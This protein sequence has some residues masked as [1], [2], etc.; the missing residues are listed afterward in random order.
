MPGSSSKTRPVFIRLPVEAYAIVERRI[1]KQAKL[2][3]VAL[4]GS[5]L[6]SLVNK[7]IKA[8]IIFF[9]RRKHVKTRLDKEAT[10]IK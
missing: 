8:T 7:Y 10:I 2:R 5:D 3:G 6:K 9:I 1:L 4:S